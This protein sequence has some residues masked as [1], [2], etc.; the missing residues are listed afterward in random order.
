M[1]DQHVNIDIKLCQ[2]THLQ[3]KILHAKLKKKKKRDPTSPS[4]DQ[5]SLMLQLRPDAAK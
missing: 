1:G 3:I 5:R 2:I 4:E